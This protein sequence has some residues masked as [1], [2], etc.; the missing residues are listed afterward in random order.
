VAGRKHSEPLSMSS[1]RGW[2]FEFESKS[3]PGNFPSGHHGHLAVRGCEIMWQEISLLL[4]LDPIR[5]TPPAINSPISGNS[6]LIL[7]RSFVRKYLIVLLLCKKAESKKRSIDILH[8][9]ST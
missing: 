2:F 4:I 1:G 9:K 7:E 6:E 3:I 5:D 8:I